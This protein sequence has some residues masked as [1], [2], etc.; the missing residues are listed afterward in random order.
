MQ[1]ID[2]QRLSISSRQ[3]SC[4]ST[5]TKAGHSTCPSRMLASV[6][7]YDKVLH[8][9]IHTRSN[10]RITKHWV[11][12]NKNVGEVSNFSRSNSCTWTC[13]MA[14]Y[15]DDLSSCHA[16]TIMLKTVPTTGMLS[17]CQRPCTS[18]CLFLATLSCCSSPPLSHLLLYPVQKST[19]LRTRV[20]ACGFRF[21]QQPAPM[22]PPTP[23]PLLLPDSCPLTIGTLNK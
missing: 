11:F 19:S 6:H 4:S 12:S 22:S 9:Q 14:S 1:Q 13:S 16:S 18:V 21:S 7:P 2:L 23:H 5:N 3:A 15:V 10:H 17:F 8:C 20:K